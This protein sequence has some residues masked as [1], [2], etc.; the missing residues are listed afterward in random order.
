M[1]KRLAEIL[2]ADEARVNI[3]VTSTDGLGAIGREEGIGAEAVVLLFAQEG[4]GLA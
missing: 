1:R 2:D 4:D 3:K